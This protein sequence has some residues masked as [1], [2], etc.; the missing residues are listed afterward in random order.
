[1][2]QHDVPDFSFLSSDSVDS[3]FVLMVVIPAAPFVPLPVLGDAVPVL[4]GLLVFFGSVV[5]LGFDDS[6]C[7]SCCFAFVDDSLLSWVKIR[8]MGEMGKGD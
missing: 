1:M 4:A 2:L 8:I 3:V 6:F 7:H 5:L